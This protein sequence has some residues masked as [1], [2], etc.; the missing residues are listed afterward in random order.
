M[1]DSF[2]YE[3]TDFKI[4]KSFNSETYNIEVTINK[5][6]TK[7]SEIKINPN[8]TG[9]NLL[10]YHGITLEN[11]EEQDCLS[12]SL[13]FSERKEDP[14]VS[15]RTQFFGKYFLY[16]RNHFDIIEEC[17]NIEKPYDRRVLFYYY[18]LMMDEN[19]LEKED[20]KRKNLHEDKLIINYIRDNLKALEHLNEHSIQEEEEKITKEENPLI[21]HFIRYK[22]QQRKLLNKLIDVY[23]SQ[24]N[25]LVKDEAL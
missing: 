3:A 22:I 14:L 21:K 18:V 11:N 16:D 5:A 13:T 12:L 1:L 6:I 7:G 20:P 19:D 8:L 25:M 2:R 17:I 9:D 4:E 23:E 24:Y 10:I 15:K